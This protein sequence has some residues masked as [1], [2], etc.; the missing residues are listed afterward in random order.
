MRQGRRRGSELAIVYIAP[1]QAEMSRF[2]FIISKRVGVAV[3][4]NR[5][6][7]QLSEIVRPMLPEDSP[8][9]VV[10]RVLPA[11]AEQSF[12]TLNSV[13]APKVLP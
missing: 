11:A 2:G 4:R 3:V 9:D 12:A 5:L 10:I 7:R 1:G 13:V 8:R 6:K